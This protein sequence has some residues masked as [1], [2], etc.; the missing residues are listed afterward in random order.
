MNKQTLHEIIQLSQECLVRFWQL[1]SEFVINF[2]DKDILWIGSAQSQYIEVYD[3]TVK[4]FREIMKEIKPC[5]ISKM[6]FTVVQN[7]G[8]TCTI[9]G[10][11]F[12]T[13][14]D[15]VGYFLQVH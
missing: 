4:D 5:H 3:E 1:D 2:F 8:N 15:D 9:A 10:R 14:D 7:T 13:T 6:E 11:Y 12:T